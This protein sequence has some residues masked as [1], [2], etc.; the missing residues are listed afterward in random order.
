VSKICSKCGEEKENNEFP[1]VGRTCKKCRKLYAKKWYQRE[2]EKK[3]ETK[4]CRKCNCEKSWDEFTKRKWTCKEC[5]RLYAKEWREKYPEKIKENNKEYSRKYPE[6]IKGYNGDYWKKNKEKLK[7]SKKEYN[8]S[9]ATYDTYS[10]QISYAESTRRDPKNLDLLQVKC[11]YCGKWYNPTNQQVSSR[12]KALEGR[13]RGGHR[14]YCTEK[15]KKLCPIYHQ[16]KYPK[17]QKPYYPIRGVQ[18]E[19][20]DMVKERD[21]WKCVKCGSTEDLIAHHREGILWE[22]LESADID[23]GITLCKECEKKVHRI[24][25]CKDKEFQCLN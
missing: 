8:K 3:S 5:K 17:G 18:K 11:V 7:K 12:I 23:V 2:E 22:P 1:K 4:I 25:G 9:D 16:Q 19:W 21:G 10:I 6:K 15:C 13:E 20:A 24:E 14:L